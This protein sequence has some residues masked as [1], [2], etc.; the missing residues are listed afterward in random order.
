MLDVDGRPSGGLFQFK[1]SAHTAGFS[2]L[3]INWYDDEGALTQIFD[4]RKDDES[5]QFKGGAALISRNNIDTIIKQSLFGADICY[6]RR[7]LDNNKYHGNI[8][9]KTNLSKQASN[10]ISQA[11]AVFVEKIIPNPS[12]EE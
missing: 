4:Q 5:I 1:E 3:S 2:E 7:E 11:I 12:A 9:R 10:T 6:E 8:L